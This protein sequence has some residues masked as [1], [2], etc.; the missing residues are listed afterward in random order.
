[1][2]TPTLQIR[3]ANIRF[4]PRFR[5]ISFLKWRFRILNLSKSDSSSPGLH[6]NTVVKWFLDKQRVETADTSK[7]SSDRTQRVRPSQ[8]LKL[9]DPLPPNS[10]HEYCSVFIRH[11]SELRL[12][13]IQAALRVPGQRSKPRF[14]IFPF[15]DA[16]LQ[17]LS[18]A[19]APAML[20]DNFEGV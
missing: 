1:L 2:L 9:N 17:S 8:A 18:R 4:R 14:I 16:Y 5:P 12:V 13:R 20:Y 11:M 19:V 7:A 15:E 10:V 6:C 3:F